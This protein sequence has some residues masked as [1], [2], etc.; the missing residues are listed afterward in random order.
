MTTVSAARRATSPVRPPWYRRRP[1]L[2]AAL[3]FG[4]LATAAWTAWSLRSSPRGFVDLDVYRLGVQAWWH[5]ADSY[6]VLPPTKVGMELPYIYPPFATIVLS[7]LAALPWAAS[8]VAMTLLS[9]GCLAVV[10]YLV[11]RRCWEPGGR[12]GAVVVSAILLPLA[13]LTEPVRDTVW[14]GQV[15]LLLLALVGLDCLVPH[16]RWPRGVL[17]GIAAAI[18]LTPA[19]F[20]VYFLA[21]RDYRAA[22]WSA[23]SGAAAT[24]L[25]FAVNWGGSLTFWFDPNTGLRSQSGSPFVTNQTVWALLQRLGLSGDIQSA[26]W[27]LALAV[28]LAVTVVGVRRPG[29][30]T[31]MA[32]VLVGGY[33]LLACPTSWGHHWV[34]CV[35]AIAAMLVHAARSRSMVWAVATVVAAGVYTAAA[36]YYMPTGPAGDPHGWNALEQ[37]LGNSFTLAA[38]AG[39]VLYAVPALVRGQET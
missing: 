14:F 31:P 27:V 22:L 26:V 18:K 2:V 33:G 19:I 29:T 28:L 37:V 17:V 25:G 3:V 32:M 1:V 24:A 11:V 16:P 13:L 8:V 35:P 21:R 36:F 34:Y 6:G 15:N 20:V 10:L 5:G 7:P 39:L 9:L 30:S 4:V 23:V 38:I 12:R